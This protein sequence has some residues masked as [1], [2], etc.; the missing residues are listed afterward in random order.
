MLTMGSSFLTVNEGWEKYLEDA[1]RTYHSLEEGVKSRLVNL[2]IEARNAME[3]ENWKDDA[4]L[5][6]LDW[7]PKIAGKSRG[8]GIPEAVGFFLF[9][10][11][12]GYA[13]WCQRLRWFLRG[14]R[15]YYASAPSAQELLI[16]LFLFS[17]DF[18]STDI[19]LGTPLQRNG[20]S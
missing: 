14:T 17:S 15:N 10:L 1:E 11:S 18:P 5:Q 7:T 6:Q 3:N 16:V 13:D 12:L 20:T 4:W 2:A 19:V 9:F 8:I